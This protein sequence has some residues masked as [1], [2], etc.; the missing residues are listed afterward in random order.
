MGCQPALADGTVTTKIC[1][2]KKER[3]IKEKYYEV[4]IPVSEYIN[5]AI[6]PRVSFDTY[7]EV[8]LFAR[9]LVEQ[10]YDVVTSIEFYEDDCVDGEDIEHEE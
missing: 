7:E 1:S 2:C 8:I 5:D 6:N 3:K 9:P 4:T 10:G